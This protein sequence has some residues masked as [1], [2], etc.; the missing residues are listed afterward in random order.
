MLQLDFRNAFNT[1]RRDH[2]LRTIR[3][4]APH[5]A[6]W[7]D[8]CYASHTPL[9]VGDSVVCST[10]VVQKHDPCGHAAFC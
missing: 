2:L 8:L 4:Q 5:V 3:D 10:S 1:L 9:F 6:P 7:L